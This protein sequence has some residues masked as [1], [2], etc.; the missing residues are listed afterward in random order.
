MKAYFSLQYRMLN[1]KFTDVRIEPFLAYAILIPGFVA[2]SVFLFSKTNYA[3]YVY[4]A[5]ALSLVG[6]LSEIRRNEFLQT[7]FKSKEYRKIRA[8][9]NLL[10]SLPFVGF[11]VYKQ[12]FLAV[13]ILIMLAT[14]L[15]LINLKTRYSFTIPTPFYKKPFEFTVGFRN[16]FFLFPIAYSIGVI[17]VSINNFNLGIFSMMALF[18]V[19]LNY[20]SKPEDEFYVWSYNMTSKQFLVDKIKTAIVYSTWLT[21]PILLILGMAFYEKWHYLLLFLVVGYAFLIAA[22]TAK[23]SV[24]PNEI[25]LTQG[26]LIA[27]SLFFPPLLLFIIPYFFS[28]SVNRL[29]SYLK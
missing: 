19:S 1:R 18:A 12:L 26:F 3:Q 7:T 2:L 16:T 20:Y 8:I 29:K 24:F 11:L 14:L 13:L 22:I 9:E 5:V 28:Q 15:S 27:T 10:V 23:Y 17:S 25:N 6:S 4:V 21:I